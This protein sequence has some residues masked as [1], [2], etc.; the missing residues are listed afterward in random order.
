MT[1]QGRT[2]L[3][4]LPTLVT[5]NESTPTDD[6]VAGFSGQAALP[7]NLEQDAAAGR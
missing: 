5:A 7:A 4:R 3:H 6:R 1:M 2:T